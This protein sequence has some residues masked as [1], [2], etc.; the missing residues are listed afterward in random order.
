VVRGPSGRGK[1]SGPTSTPTAVGRH[2]TTSP[3]EVSAIGSGTPGERR[4]RSDGRRPVTGTTDR[5][6]VGG[7]RGGDCAA[8]VAED[9]GDGD[10]T[11]GVGEDEGGGY[12]DRWRG[13]RRKVGGDGGGVCA[14]V[15]GCVCLSV[16]CVCVM[17]FVC[18]KCVTIGPMETLS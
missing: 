14:C 8:S 9:E 15:C 2:G 4:W 1:R 5:R 6:G 10:R 16:W 12:R 18:V 17:C 7:G 3:S 13:R 11:A